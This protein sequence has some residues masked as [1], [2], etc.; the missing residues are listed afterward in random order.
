MTTHP[1]AALHQAMTIEHRG[2]GAFGRDGDPGKS[3]HEA[4]AD[5]AGTPGAMLALH[6]QDVVLDLERQLVRIVMG[7]P[8]S[9]RQP[10]HPALFVTI[11]DLVARLTGDFK[12]PAQIRHLLAG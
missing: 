9:I 5:L 4:L 12:L 6:V 10:L 11:K 8:A 3:A 1:A 2:D 7:A